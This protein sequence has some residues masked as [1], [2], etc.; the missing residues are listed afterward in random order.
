MFPQKEE[1]SDPY[2]PWCWYIYIQNWVICMANVGK[3]TAKHL[4]LPAPVGPPS[5]YELETW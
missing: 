3:Y 5:S 2:A 1:V 4:V